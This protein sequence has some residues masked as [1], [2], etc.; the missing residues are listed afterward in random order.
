MQGDR[1]NIFVLA[2][3]NNF[4]LKILCSVKQDFKCIKFT[5]CF[6]CKIKKYD[7]CSFFVQQD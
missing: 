6:V 1:L 3:I 4:Y 5:A 2:P 7:R